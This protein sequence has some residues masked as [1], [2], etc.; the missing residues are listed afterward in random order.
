MTKSCNECGVLF[1]AY[2][3]VKVGNQLMI[4]ENCLRITCKQCASKKR[5]KNKCPD[6]KCRGPL[7]PLDIEE[8][9]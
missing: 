3:P 2:E 5:N 1:N 4:C 9:D 8:L 7:R 6:K